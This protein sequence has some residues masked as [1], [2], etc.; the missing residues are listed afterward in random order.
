MKKIV[1]V[2]AVLALASVASADNFVWFTASGAAVPTQGVAGGDLSVLTNSSYQVQVWL[3]CTSNIYGYDIALT[4]P[5]TAVAGAAPGNGAAGWTVDFNLG[6]TGANLYHMGQS[7]ASTWSGPA[8]NV[9]T[10]TLNTTG[11]THDIIAG[12]SP[13]GFGWGD[14]FGNYPAAWF[15]AHFLPNTDAGQWAGPAI[16]VIPEPATLVLLGLGAVALLRRR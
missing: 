2:L 15:G 12:S 16:H 5:D 11:T 4:G 7:G 13:N 14:E 1:A 10:F 8:V 9:A 3:S 6:G